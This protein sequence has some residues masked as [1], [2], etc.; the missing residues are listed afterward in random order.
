MHVKITDFGLS[1]EGYGTELRTHCGTRLY[2]APEVLLGAAYNSTVDVYSTG[3]MAGEMCF[4]SRFVRDHQFRTQ[5]L[6]GVEASVLFRDW[7][8]QTLTNAKSR[9]S[10]IEAL[11][12][13]W[14]AE[15]EASS[16]TAS[17]LGSSSSTLDSATS[18][19]VP[20]EELCS[21]YE[22]SMTLGANNTLRLARDLCPPSR[23][24]PN[25]GPYR[26]DLRHH[27]SRR[28]S[29]ISREYSSPKT[30]GC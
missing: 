3:M 19:P 5:A 2:C 30:K 21:H 25:I 24:A 12:H 22:G 16:G 20:H 4:G 28:F 15:S 8:D 26:S 1:K 13:H 10:F 17:T 9:M 29:P 7:L 11:S 23:I 14:L 18:D 27:H 6:S